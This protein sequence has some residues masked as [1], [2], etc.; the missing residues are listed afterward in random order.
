[1]AAKIRVH[2]WVRRTGIEV[3]GWTCVVVGCAALVLPGPGLLMLVG[4]LAILSQQYAWARRRLAPMKARAFHAAA[5]GVK[6][7]PRIAASCLCAFAVMGCGVV[8]TVQPGVPAWWP[9]E[10]R[11][12]L[13]GGSATGISMVLSSLIALVLIIYSVRRFRGKPPPGKTAIP[14]GG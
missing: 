1:M 7:I 10:S 8:W 14:E 13:F 5:I 3:T 9:L 2:G 12:W 11:W 4:G 6:T